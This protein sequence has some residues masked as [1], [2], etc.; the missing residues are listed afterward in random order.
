MKKEKKLMDAITDVPDE[1]IEEAKEKGGLLPGSEKSP[2]K[3][4]R[5]A[6]A[7]A[8]C[9][10]LIAAGIFSLSRA[11]LGKSPTEN[12][13][14][15]AA[16]PLMEVSMPPARSFDDWET[17]MKVREENPV[18]ESF[19][20]SLSSFSYET[21]SALFAGGN[22]N[23][24]YSPV[25]LY[26]ALAMAATGAEGETK[27][28]LLSLLGVQDTE[29]LK[30]QCGNYYRRSYTENEISTQ[31]ISNSL[32][33]DT[34]ASWKQSFVE[35]AAEN[36]YASVFSMELGTEE[37]AQAMSH[38]IKEQ[39]DGSLSPNLSS[40]G[41]TALSLINT[42]LF[43]DEWIDQFDESKTKPDS[44][45]PS[46]DSPVT[47][48]FMNRTYDSHG[49]CVGEGYTRS[50]LSLK[51][52]SMVFIL[53]DEGVSPRSLIDTPEKMRETFEG[54]ESYYGEVVWQIPKFDFSSSLE[55]GDTLKALGITSAFEETADFSGITDDTV[56][57]SG[58]TQGTHIAVN[59]EGVDASAFT[60]IDYAGAAMPQGR[61][62]MR[63]TRP[64][65]YGVTGAGG[66][67]VF[68][69]I[70]ENPVN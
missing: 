65:L 34:S 33:L 8:A 47:C 48:D 70:C 26:Y 66:E 54:G 16:R 17:A 15:E 10:L 56:F 7:F 60:L 12:P 30:E 13:R 3:I 9:L 43:H 46:E 62:D 40:G 44:F 57:F 22:E 68:V 1:M 5:Y 21:A 4:F 32:W 41:E 53:P 69:G 35:N 52:G 14:L 28:E 37:A 11:K 55:L 20:D 45:Y 42:V 19:T 2:G 29:T 23:I 25:S 67:L 18:E 38:W 64:F 39:T 51:N 24:N 59:E 49:F 27:E 58:I 61:A 31:K 6:L 50:S 63:L 36:F